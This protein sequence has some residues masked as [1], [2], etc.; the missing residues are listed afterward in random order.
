MLVVPFGRRRLLGVVVELAERSELPAERLV[1]PLA[2]LEADVPEPLVRLGL[3]VAR[4]YVSTPARGLAL[5]LPPGTGTGAGRPLRPRRSLRAALT[6]EGRRALASRV[7]LGRRQ[8]AVL[9]ALT[10][11]PASVAAVARHAGADHST[12]RSLERRGLVCLENA[13]EPAAA[14]FTRSRGRPGGFGGADG[15]PAGGAPGS[16]RPPGHRSLA[17][18]SSMGSPAA[19][20][21]RST[22]ARQRPPSSGAARRSCSCRRSRSPRRPRAASLS[23]SAT[24]WRSCT[25]ACRRASATTSGGECAAARRASASARARRSS[26]PSRTSA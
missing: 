24:P 17:R 9:D 5:V 6:E 14:A 13:A 22:C 23:A 10:A 15:R 25:P 4:E 11:G 20:R 16:R 3:W 26:H 12:V 18:F 7:R 8:A 2:A 1:Q 19:A 21:P